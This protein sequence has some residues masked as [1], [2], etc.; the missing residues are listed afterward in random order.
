[1][2]LQLRCLLPNPKV[3]SNLLS[4]VVLQL[5]VTEALFH[6]L[7]TTCSKEEITSRE[8]NKIKQTKK[9]QQPKKTIKKTAQRNKFSSGI[10][11]HSS[12]SCQRKEVQPFQPALSLTIL[13]FYQHTK[14]IQKATDQVIVSDQIQW[15]TLGAWSP[16][17]VKFPLKRNTEASTMGCSALLY[18]PWG[19]GTP[20]WVS[21][22]VNRS[23]RTKNHYASWS[24]L[25]RW[26]SL[27]PSAL[28]N[29]KF[30]S[31]CQGSVQ[32]R[33]FNNENITTSLKKQF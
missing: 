15:I 29:V 25:R 22:T 13:L 9:T 27:Y 18:R 16:T 1:M 14:S 31:N 20:D 19:W 33:I 30:R 11:K 10:R 5:K 26:D 7:P 3:S 24:D 4:Q 2:N 32:Y 28:K 17:L 12:I 23:S 8:K 21:R 6:T